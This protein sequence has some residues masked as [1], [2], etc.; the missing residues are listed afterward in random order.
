MNLV[1]QGPALGNGDLDAIA[2]LAKPKAKRQ[3]A[4]H[5]FRFVDAMK[6]EGIAVWKGFT[7]LSRLQQ[8]RRGEVRDEARRPARRRAGRTVELVECPHCGAFH[9]PTTGCACRRPGAGPT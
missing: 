6:N 9:D 3:I 2:L 1:V 4:P 8:T 7:M 5:A